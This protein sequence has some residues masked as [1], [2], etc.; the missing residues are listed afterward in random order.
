MSNHNSKSPIKLRHLDHPDFMVLA[1]DSILRSLGGLLGPKYGAIFVDELLSDFMEA[2]FQ[3]PKA[4]TLSSSN[5][6]FAGWLHE[7]IGSLIVTREVLRGSFSVT[8][9]VTPAPD[10]REKRRKRI[11]LSLASSIVPLLVGSSLWNLPLDNRRDLINSIAT[12]NNGTALSPQTLQRNRILVILLMELIGTFCQLLGPDLKEVLVTVFYPIVEKTTRRGHKTSSHIIHQTGLSTLRIMSLSYGFDDIEDLI[13]A[14]QNRLVSAMIGR[15]RLPGGSR[16]PNTRDEAEEI[17]SVTK[18]SIWLLEM[19]NRKI[20][21]TN[22]SANTEENDEEEFVGAK[23][24]AIMDLIALLNYRLDHLFLQKVMTDADIE[25]VCSLHKAFFNCFLHLFNV[26]KEKT[27]SYQMKNLEKDSKEPWL[28]LLSQFRKRPPLGTEAFDISD[29][30]NNENEGNLL[31]FSKSDI[32]L[33]AKLIARDC[34]LLSYQNLE[35]RISSCD[36]LTI[37][38]KFLAFVGS[39][40]D[41]PTDDRNVIRNTILRQGADSWP[42]IRARLKSLSEIIL[43]SY[44]NRGSN[45]VLVLHQSSREQKKYEDIGTQRIFL[46]KLFQLIAVM[47]ECSGDFFVD[48]FRNDV[49]PCMARHLEYLLQEL[50]RQREAHSSSDRIVFEQKFNK[51]I[52]NPMIESTAKGN[53]LSTITL[54]ER[55]LSFKISDTQEQLIVSILRCLNRIL[56]QEECGKAL[57]KLLGSIGS[58][59]LPLLDVEDQPKIQEMSMD[60]IRSIV[61][62]DSDVL[63]RPLIELSG[64]K[65][66]ACPLKFRRDLSGVGE[67]SGNSIAVGDKGGVFSHRCRELLVFAD[68]LPE[69]AIS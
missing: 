3:M 9:V 17:F 36:A 6:L 41:D 47:C 50:Q 57:E 44:S 46:S 21:A 53:E 10:K 26:D 58:T 35:S 29:E 11:L 33:F 2:S 7:W 56:E 49:W 52:R 40:H 28:D 60:C 15:L 34:Y 16:I 66:Q 1:R 19:I 43:Q 54:S 30:A 4:N 69:Q 31:D 32:D 38:F 18:T 5:D 12:D 39:E 8:P 23:S 51:A 13:H 42:S 62:I 59:I 63:R 25:T 65:I 61:K 22:G 37:A 55:R 14:E 68:S 48:R 67:I 24:S 64:T 27:Y 45:V 20:E